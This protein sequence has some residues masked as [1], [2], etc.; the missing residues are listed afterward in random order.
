MSLIFISYRRG[1]SAGYAGRLH[2]S[3]ERR[4]GE[5]TVFRDVDRLQPGQDFVSAIST[6]LRDCSACLVL[7]GRQWLDVSDATGV[8]R[9]T[10]P[11]DYVRLEIEAALAR[12]D[13]LVVPILVEGA[14]MPQTKDLPPSIRPLTRRHAL[15]LRDESWD[16]DVDRL[17]S[18]LAK[19]IGRGASP[20]ALP[21][22][23]RLLPT[24]SP[25]ALAWGTVILALIAVAFFAQT[26]QRAD[27]EAPLSRGASTTQAGDTTPSDTTQGITLPRLAE[28]AHRHLLYTVLAGDVGPGPEGRIVRLRIRISN[29]G[30]LP[31]NFW[32]STFRLALKG[33]TSSATSGINSIVSGHSVEQAVFV[34]PIP[35]GTA[36]ATLEIAN[37]DAVARIPLDLRPSGAASR[38]DT[39]D[40]GD[41]LSRADVVRLT[42]DATALTSGKGV[43]Y[44]LVSLTVRRF[45]NVL[46][47]VADIRFVNT[48]PYPAHFSRDALR[49]IV[50]NQPIAPFD[51]PNQAVDGD[52]T[53][54]GAYVVDV[55]PSTRHFGLRVSG[56]PAAPLRFDVPGPPR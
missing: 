53:A 27:G 3:L 9:L 25:K 42:T 16:A 47:I 55:P 11:D 45:V 33:Q 23:H 5:G 13:L 44:T 12:P 2:E 56:A 14:T 49:V 54:N 51:G 7:V 28:A 21:R 10:L 1:E 17:C 41:A 36:E 30:S 35:V 26:L 32:D 52:S 48:G 4:F 37:Q 18:A 22:L 6:S 43:R 8:R 31:A 24:G 50:D 46:R 38:V 40:S 29:E 19:A 20:P 39:P 34:F 15:S